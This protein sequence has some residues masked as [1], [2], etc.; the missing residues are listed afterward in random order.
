[1]GGACRVSG[2]VK[3]EEMKEEIGGRGGLVMKLFMLA[4]VVDGLEKRLSFGGARY[5]DRDY[6]RYPS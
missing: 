3:S 2:E 4:R 5:N 6:P 1:M